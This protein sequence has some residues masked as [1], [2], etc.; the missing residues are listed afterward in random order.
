[1]SFLLIVEWLEVVKCVWNKISVFTFNYGWDTLTNALL[2]LHE[3]NLAKTKKINP[4]LTKLLRYMKEYF[5][6]MCLNFY[7]KKPSG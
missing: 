3:Q 2:E 4:I 1:M 7:L 5:R 6:N